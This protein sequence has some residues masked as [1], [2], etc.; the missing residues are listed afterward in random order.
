MIRTT[1]HIHFQL[2]KAFPA[3]R[4][5]THF[6]RNC[7]SF[8]T[9]DN[10][11][12]IFFNFYIFILFLRLVNVTQVPCSEP[13]QFLCF[14]RLFLSFFPIFRA[15]LTVSYAEQIIENFYHVRS[16]L[17]LLFHRTFHHQ[18]L[19]RGRGDLWLLGLNS[20]GKPPTMNCI[21]GLLRY[22]SSTLEVMGEKMAAVR[23]ISRCLPVYWFITAVNL[24]GDYRTLDA[25]MRAELYTA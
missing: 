11:H 15:F 24:L 7:F 10:S 12:D 8:H 3:H 13:E 19:R 6:L 16:G 22:D 9:S 1:H 23:P 17:F 20:S 18:S 25:G 2:L 4:I 21:L 5:L 14:Q